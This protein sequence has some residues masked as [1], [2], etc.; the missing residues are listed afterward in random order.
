[1]NSNQ[2]LDHQFIDEPLSMSVHP[3]GIFISI[4]FSNKIQIFGYTIDGLNIIKQL[5]ISNAK[6]V[7]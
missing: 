7:S 3:T 2:E 5:N 4:L 1:M 6:I